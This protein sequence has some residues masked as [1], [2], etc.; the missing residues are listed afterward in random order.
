MI[1]GVISTGLVAARENNKVDR[2]YNIGLR[3]WVAWTIPTLIWG[4][5]LLLHTPA[6]IGPP[7][8]ISGIW[9]INRRRELAAYCA[10]AKIRMYAANRNWNKRPTAHLINGIAFVF[11][12]ATVVLGLI[13]ASLPWYG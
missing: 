11:M 9:Q 2:Q 4:I 7:M 13:F 12:G 1:I 8:I 5:G 6:I 3:Y 10:T